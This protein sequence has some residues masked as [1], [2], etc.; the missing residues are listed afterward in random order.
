MNIFITGG[1]GFLGRNLQKHISAFYP[2]ASVIAPTRHECNLLD[3][4]SLFNYNSAFDVIFH[5]A[6]WT[7]AG[8][9]CL[10]YPGDQWINNQYINSNVLNWWVNSTPKAHLV[11]MG[12]SCSYDPSMPLVEDNYLCG[13]PIDSL[14]TYAHTKRMLLIGA[15]SI[16]K[17][18]GLS[19][20]CFVPST[21]YGANYH[22][23]GR[24]LHFIFDLIRKLVNSKYHGTQSVLWGDGS[25]RR[26]LVHVDDFVYTMLSILPNVTNEIINIG[27]GEDYSINEFA[28]L[29]CEI[30]DY[31]PDHILYDT[32]KYVGAKSKLLSIDKLKRYLP[33]YCQRPL[34][35]GLSESIDWY[36][37]SK[38]FN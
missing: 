7:Q 1:N 22:D 17:Q 3:P 18:Y 33:D 9:F 35:E 36:K 2:D 19:Y 12:T 16:S 23:D 4:N 30:I 8:D 11:F 20:S 37:S 21:L 32:T 27:A 38:L 26:E 13:R 29:I 5:L 31:N 25:Q 34:I 14:Y 28:S 10:K 15:E 6:A 24:Q